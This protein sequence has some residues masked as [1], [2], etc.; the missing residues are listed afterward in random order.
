MFKTMFGEDF[1]GGKGGSFSSQ[2][3]DGRRSFTMHFSSSGGQSGDGF[4]GGF[5]GG[6][7]G[8]S[9]FGNAFRNAQQRQ[10]QQRAGSGGGGGGGGRQGELTC[11]PR[12]AVSA[13][14]R[15]A[16]TPGCIYIEMHLLGSGVDMHMLC[17]L[18]CK[19]ET[20]PFRGHSGSQRTPSL[21][22]YPLLPY[23]NM[24][25]V[26]KTAHALHVHRG[27]NARSP[28]TRLTP[29]PSTA[30]AASFRVCGQSAWFAPSSHAVIPHQLTCGRVHV[31]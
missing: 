25:A 22:L 2:S 10:Q 23:C 4:A 15:G 13:R 26:V 21:L 20:L 12:S 14:S 3:S 11:P 7:G 28:V 6:D 17:K 31:K 16:F 24:L 9:I 1:G 27:P 18:F 8:G 29:N 19:C 30:Q 5:G